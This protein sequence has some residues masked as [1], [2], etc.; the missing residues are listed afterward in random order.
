MLDLLFP[1]L[2]G[3]YGLKICITLSISSHKNTRQVK[4]QYFLTYCTDIKNVVSKHVRVEILLFNAYRDNPRR[5]SKLKVKLQLLWRT[6]LKEHFGVM[7]NLNRRLQMIL[8]A[9]GSHTKYVVV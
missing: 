8:D 3:R 2:Y 4:C 6:S 5:L 7:E 9:H 1:L